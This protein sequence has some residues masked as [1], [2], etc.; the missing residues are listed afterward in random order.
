[1]FFTDVGFRD[2]STC[3]FLFFFF[4]HCFSRGV[5]IAVYE[6]KIWQDSLCTHLDL[7]A[8][9]SSCCKKKAFSA[10]SHNGASVPL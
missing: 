4:K 6:L 10:V 8:L 5:G 9:T 2:V 7:G 1:M 3:L